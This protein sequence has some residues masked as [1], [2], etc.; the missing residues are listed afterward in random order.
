MNEVWSG[1]AVEGRSGALG[2]GE[3]AFESASG[4]AEFE[5]FEMKAPLGENR[6]ETDLFESQGAADMI[7]E[8]D[9]LAVAAEGTFEPGE[10]GADPVDEC[11]GSA[12]V[13]GPLATFPAVYEAVVWSQF[14]PGIGLPGGNDGALAGEDVWKGVDEGQ[15]GVNI[16]GNRKAIFRK[17]ASG[18]RVWRWFVGVRPR[19]G[20]GSGGGGWILAR[21]RHGI[22]PCDFSSMAAAEAGRLFGRIHRDGLT[23]AVQ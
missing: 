7:L 16:L 11:S 5:S 19:G 18:L 10:G 13:D 22:D 1:E 3:G 23:G 8:A 4:A 14:S 6:V 20:T 12:D 15:G 21:R 2:L 17:G 9:E